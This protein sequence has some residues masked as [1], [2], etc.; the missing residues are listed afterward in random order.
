MN[1]AYAAVARRAE[2]RCEYCHAPEVVFNFPL[3]VEHIVP[4]QRGGSGELDNLALACR[5]C[6]LFKSDKISMNISY[7]QDFHFINVAI[8]SLMPFSKGINF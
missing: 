6:N 5:A 7:Y 1:A 2:H 4:P 3:E 8:T